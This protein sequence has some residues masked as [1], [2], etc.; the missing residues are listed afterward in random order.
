MDDGSGAVAALTDAQAQNSAYNYNWYQVLAHLSTSTR[1]LCCNLSPFFDHG[2]CFF[3]PHSNMVAGDK[4]P[5]GSMP[6]ITSITSIILLPP[7]DG[8]I[9]QHGDSEESILSCPTLNR[10]LRLVVMEISVQPQILICSL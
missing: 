4:T 3:F 5:G 2:L 8:E 1:L 7:H 10:T 6:N 9:V